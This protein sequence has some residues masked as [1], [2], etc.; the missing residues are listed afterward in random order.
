MRLWKS[1]SSDSGRPEREKGD[2][3]SRLKKDIP[4]MRNPGEPP[5]KDPAH[6]SGFL[7]DLCNSPFAYHELRQCILCGRWA[8]QSCW[9]EEFYVCNSC[10]GMITLHTLLG[11]S[12]K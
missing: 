9:T 3:V 6:F 10:N 8:C 12:T 1:R 11:K 7:C 4:R 2:L 5:E